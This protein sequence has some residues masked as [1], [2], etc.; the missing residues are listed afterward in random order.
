METDLKASIITVQYFCTHTREK[1]H[2]RRNAKIYK[3]YKFPSDCIAAI[4]RKQT[5]EFF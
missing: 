4:Y 2:F 5:F 1:Y 3:I